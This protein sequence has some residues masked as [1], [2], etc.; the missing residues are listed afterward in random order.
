MKKNTPTPFRILL[1][2]ALLLASM[3]S[4]FGTARAQ[5]GSGVALSITENCGAVSFDLSWQ[6]TAPFLLQ[7]DYGDGDAT[8]IL[9]VEAP[10]IILDHQYI[11][12]GDYEWTLVIGDSTGWSDSITDTLTIEGPEIVLTSSPFP[13]LILYGQDGLV[14][15]TTSV[16]GGT[17]DYTYSWDLDGDGVAEPE[18]GATASFTYSEV[19]KYQ[20]QVTVTDGC[21][22]SSSAALPVVVSDPEDVCHPTAQKIADGVNTLFPDQSGDLYTCEDIYAIFDNPE[23]ENNIGFGRMWMAYRLALSME[24]LSWEDILAWHLDQSGWGSL[25]QLDR[26]AELLGD[27]SLTELMGLVVSG[28]YTLGDVRTAVRAAT[29]DEADFD[30]ALARIAVGATPGELTQFYKLASDLKADPEAL[31]GY[32]AEGLTL[33]ELRHTANFADRV[34]VDWTEVADARSAADSWGDINQAYRL[35]TDEISAA[36]ILIMGVQEYK[37]SLQGE[38]K[39]DREEDKA[40]QAQEKEQQTG[41]RLAEQFSA[42]FGEVM[43]LYNGECLGDW[44]CVRQSL[45]EQQRSMAEGFSEKDYQTALQIGSKYGYTQEE[46]LAYHRDYCS[47]DWSCTRAYFRELF[48]SSQGKGKP[49][50]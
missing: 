40:Q 38:A 28:D 26:F 21:L 15:F 18:T 8:E 16:S 19:G 9:S 46:V 44:A 30:D 43:S 29:N 1:A 42:E 31:D 12:Q 37:E 32:L 35:A 3:G 5:D 10:D 34:E 11:D 6:G 49:D 41:E 17:P 2:L 4:A 47:L 23:D 20:A 39:A 33:S 24:E 36:E 13:P 7:M 45:K 48:M 50:K 27:H 22:F 25:L 14:E